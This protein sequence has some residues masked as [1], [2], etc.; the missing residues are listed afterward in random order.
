MKR[1]RKK[2]MWKKKKK[3]KGSSGLQLDIRP[4]SQES[5]VVEWNFRSSGRAHGFFG[6][7]KRKMQK[8][9]EYALWYF[10]QC[11]MELLV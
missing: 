10:E 1:M 7:V 5:D 2:R 11:P 3:K 8:M 9:M 6:Q 4:R